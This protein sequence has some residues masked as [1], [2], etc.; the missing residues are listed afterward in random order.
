MRREG[1]PSKTLCL[2]Q[3]HKEDLRSS[4]NPWCYICYLLLPKHALQ[5]PIYIFTNHFLSLNVQK[6]KS[7]K[8]QYH[9]R[10]AFIADFGVD[11][12]GDLITFHS[13]QPFADNPPRILRRPKDDNV[14]R[15]K[16]SC[17]GRNSLH[18]QQIACYGQS[19]KHART[20]SLRVPS[21]CRRR[22]KFIKV[23]LKPT[24]ENMK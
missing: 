16:F 15:S 7:K 8:I 6:W 12:V 4:S 23:K 13:D 18:Q 1:Q 21:H 24:N 11:D 22:P 19:W 14:T 20:I 3:D 9:N 5:E 10:I 17:S 2:P